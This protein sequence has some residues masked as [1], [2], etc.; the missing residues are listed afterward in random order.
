MRTPS[1]KARSWI[2]HYHLNMATHG[3]KREVMKRLG[4]KTYDEFYRLADQCQKYEFIKGLE[5]DV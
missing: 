2:K 4:L 1:K 3:I 5:K